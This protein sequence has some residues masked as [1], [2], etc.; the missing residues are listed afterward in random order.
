MPTYT[1]TAIEAASGRKRAGELDSADVDTAIGA[2]KTRGLH[3]IALAPMT[4]PDEGRAGRAPAGSAWVAPGGRWPRLRRAAGTKELTIL[5][6]QL[7]ALVNAGM[8]LVRS[9]DLL[10]RQERNPA[11]RAVIAGLADVIRAGG[12]LSDG[13]RRHPKIFDRLYVG[14]IQAGESG[15]TL[16]LVLDRLARHLEKVGQVRARMKAAMT[17]PVVIMVVAVVIVAGL[18]AFV[19][20]R[21]EAIF[22]GVLKGAPLPALTQAVLGASRWVEQHGWGLLGALILL[23]LGARWLR[24]TAAG[25]RA[26]DRLCL[27]LPLLG[28]LLLKAAIARFSR[29]L[30]SMLASGVPIL[31]ALQLTRDACGNRTVGEAIGTVHRRVREGEGV[32]R[33]LAATGVFPPVVA[34]M[35]EVGEETGTLPAMLARIADL[36]DEEVDN[37]VAG[38]TS[39]LEPAMIVIMALVVGTIVLALFLPIIRIIQMLGV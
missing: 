20:P 36:Y 11:W 2:L 10:A 35:V 1:Y 33:P 4:E 7:A 24:H 8:P 31:E 6:R 34:G 22:V 38:L 26:A 30:G 15:G 29:T 37:T 39:L 13:L 14:M 18:M 32:A 5:T 21:F 3:P 19:V 25:A 12:T 16:D 9:L 28:A 27:R 23:G 17:Y